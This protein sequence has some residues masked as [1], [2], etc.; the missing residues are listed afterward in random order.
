[1]HALLQVSPHA[2][3]CAAVHA[4]VHAAVMLLSFGMQS[5]EALQR[6]LL[7]LC[8]QPAKLCHACISAMSCIQLGSVVQSAE[9][10]QASGLQLLGLYKAAHH[11]G[12]R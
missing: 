3:V 11:D 1:M 12:S 10:C 2:A 9:W 6:T 5:A 7:K 4:A 8:H